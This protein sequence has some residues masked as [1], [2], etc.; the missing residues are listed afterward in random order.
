MKNF[1][2]VWKGY[3]KD[4]VKAYL[5]YIIDE[6]EKL[7]NDKKQVDKELKELEEKLNYYTDLESRMN[8]A[9]FNAES[10]GDDIKKSARI[11]AESI[12]NEAKKNANR[13]INDALLK[14]EKASEQADRIKRNAMLLKNRLKRIVE[15]QLEVIEEIDRLDFNDEL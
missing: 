4:Q 7:L 10:A 1:E 9:I 3:D 5:D 2:T 15:G 6:Y 12:V 13:I 14:A 11:E 8:R